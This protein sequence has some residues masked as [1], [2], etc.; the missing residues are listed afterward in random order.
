MD[1]RRTLTRRGRGLVAAVLVDPKRETG[2]VVALNLRHHLL[3]GYCF[4]RSDYPW[5]T[6][7]EENGAITAQPWE[8]RTE[9]R[10]LEF[11]TTPLALPR[12]EN[13]AMGKLFNTPTFDCVPAYGRKLVHY[14]AFLAMVPADFDRVSDIRIE[15]DRILVL[16]DDHKSPVIVP[17]RGLGRTNLVSS[18]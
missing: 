4:Q 5:V 9:A 8:G 3:I 17:A 7:W 11:G 13:Y 2:F 12:R 1:L 16:G 14:A 18:H 15:Q 10:G 6:I